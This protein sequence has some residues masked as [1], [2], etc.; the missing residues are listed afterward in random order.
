MLKVNVHSWALM[1]YHGNLWDV[2]EFIEKNGA[3][4][5]FL[6]FGRKEVLF[7]VNFWECLL[8]GKGICVRCSNYL[9]YMMNII[10]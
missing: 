10:K 4:L 6:L 2:K 9:K 7:R 1:G 5:R 8:W 3:K